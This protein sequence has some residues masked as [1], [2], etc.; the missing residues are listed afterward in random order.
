MGQASSIEV[1]EESMGLKKDASLE[2]ETGSLTN[3]PIR[4]GLAQFHPDGKLD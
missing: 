2:M 1:D 4:P 3:Q